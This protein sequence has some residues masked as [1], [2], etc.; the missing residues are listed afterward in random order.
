MAYYL[1]NKDIFRLDVKENYSEF[2][3]KLNLRINQNNVYSPET[4]KHCKYCL[5]RHGCEKYEESNIDTSTYDEFKIDKNNLFSN[6][7]KIKNI[8]TKKQTNQPEKDFIQFTKDKEKALEKNKTD[9]VISAGAGTGKTEVLS[10]KYIKLLLDENVKVDNIVCITFTNK[11]VGEMKNRI[12]NKLTE[13]IESGYFF[14]VK[15]S[16]YEEYK[17]S[18]EKKNKLII[19]KDDFYKKNRIRTFHSF[20]KNILDKHGRKSNILKDYDLENEMPPD[21]ILKEEKNKNH[22]TSK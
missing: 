9:I 21:Y 13:T 6:Y 11:A 20:C 1:S 16:T 17:L 8:F 15:K 5:L 2:L 12:I 19:A 10:S 22:Q 14:A 4:N 18:N 7:E 3:K